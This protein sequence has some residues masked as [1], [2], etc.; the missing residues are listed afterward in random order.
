MYYKK[1]EIAFCGR[2][3][4]S[5]TYFSLVV[6]SS[7]RDERDPPLSSD[8]QKNNK[9]SEFELQNNAGTVNET[10]DSVSS[11][12]LVFRYIHNH[13]S[14]SL[15]AATTTTSPAL[16]LVLNEIARLYR[17]RDCV[18][19]RFT[20]DSS[21]S[22]V[23]VIAAGE[24]TAAAAVAAG[25]GGGG[26]QSNDAANSSS[27]IVTHHGAHFTTYANLN[28]EMPASPMLLSSTT[29][30]A[31]TTTTLAA[32]PSPLFET[33][34]N[35]HTTTAATAAAFVLLNKQ[36]N[37][38]Y[39]NKENLTVDDRLVYVSHP[40]HQFNS[41]YQQQHHH[42]H[43]HSYQNA[44]TTSFREDLLA[45]DVSS[46]S[47]LDDNQFESLDDASLNKV[48]IILRNWENVLE[49][50]FPHIFQIQTYNY[51]DIYFVDVYFVINNANNNFFYI[52][53]YRNR[54]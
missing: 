34:E 44:F 27:T 6:L 4:E 40:N 7:N 39:F 43:N 19:N 51:I 12:C 18:F 25:C 17:N 5:D 46:L 47:T 14:S 30:T 48:I 36:T 9:N 42:H 29:T 54:P 26:G 10:V 53:C 22:T 21:S 15:S 33:I 49:I 41:N 37:D 1:S 13:V 52:F 16:E 20:L 8:N 11:S 38:I 2:I 31:T 28:Y 45:K 3:K 35:S 24:A 32:Q 50:N 23:D